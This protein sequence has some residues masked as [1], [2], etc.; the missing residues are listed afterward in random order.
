[1]RWIAI[2][3]QTTTIVVVDFVL[4]YP[5]PFALTLLTVAASAVL[6]VFLI[7]RYPVSKQLSDTEAGGYL[8]T[9]PSN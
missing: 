7:L 3:G 9:T 2:G 8:F 4:D 5:F 1:M 6:N